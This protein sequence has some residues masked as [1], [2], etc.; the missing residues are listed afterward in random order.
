M[1]I[2]NLKLNSIILISGLLFYLYL[3]FLFLISLNIFKPRIFFTFESLNLIHFFIILAILNIA[4]FYFNKNF[5]KKEI[6]YKI[7]SKDGILFFV[8]SIAII[9]IINFAKYLIINLKNFSFIFLMLM[10]LFYFLL[11]FPLY[12]MN[13]F[14]LALILLNFKILNLKSKDK[15]YNI[16]EGQELF[17]KL[18]ILVNFIRRYNLNLGLVL[19]YISNINL[20]EKEHGKNGVIFLRKQLNFLLS[21]NIRSYEL[22]G[23]NESKDVYIL[24][25]AVHKEDEIKFILERFLQ[26]IKKFKFMIYDKELELKIKSAGFFINNSILNSRDFQISNLIENAIKNLKKQSKEI[27]IYRNF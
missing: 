20:I 15:I 18:E 17:G 10:I 21:Q 19:F 24:F 26:I 16:Y 22:V 1:K 9:L 7:D 11:L 13:K 6:I 14:I 8:Y 23:R 3:I 25:V 2:K 12:N 5:L 27:F 4:H